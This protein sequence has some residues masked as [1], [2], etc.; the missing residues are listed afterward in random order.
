MNNSNRYD[1]IYKLD[2]RP[3]IS[4]A[5]PLG[6]QHVLAMFVGN[7]APIFILTGAMSTPDAPFPAE[8]RIMMIQC[9]M[10]VSGLVTLVQL[11]PLKLGIIQIGARLPIVMGTAFAF[12]PTMQELGAKLMAE[13]VA[14]IEAM[15]YVLGGVIAGS[16]VEILMG[17]FLKPLKR[18]FSPLVIGAVLITIG[19]KLLTT[20]ATYFVG[21][22]AAE[23]IG[24]GKYWLVGGVVFLIII[25]LNRFA[26]G[27]WK[28]TAILIGIV[29]GYILA[30][31]MGM[32][33]LDNV[34][35][36]AWVSLP[37][38]L[39]IKPLF[40]MDIVF[41]FFAV[42]VVSGLE[43]MGNTSGI[44][45]STFDREATAEETSGAIIADAVGSSLAG[46]FNVLPNTAFGQNAGIIA[47]TKVVN[48]FCIAMGALVLMLAGLF[49]K[50]GAIFNAMP[51]CVMGGAVITVFAMIFLNG[52]KMILK[53][54]L[55]DRNSLVLAIILGL[56][57]GIGSLASPVKENF[58]AVFR[59]IFME[60]VAAVCIVGILACIV[61]KAHAD[62]SESSSES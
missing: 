13:Q 33:N 2:G 6:L 53:E 44:T 8:L 17:V 27:M 28:A 31:L 21:G 16:V 47:M 14:P 30:A 29:V 35:Q 51:N 59:I 41:P 10:F 1:L 34:S 56:G 52:V 45:I 7:L 18:F 46:L 49:P 3:P 40:R 54:G 15:G 55:D 58:P 62:V 12:V 4:V 22:A 25:V 23:D 36:A 5:L 61:F 43:T 50:I 32:V 48:R 37:M 39:V 9:A 11:Y 24:A 26:T 42:Y 20:G 38:P 60:P 19:I 57:Y